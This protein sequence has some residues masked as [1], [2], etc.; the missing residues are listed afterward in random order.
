MGAVFEVVFPVFALIA[1]GYALGKSPL[2]AG[3]AG[4]QALTS[5]VFYAAIPALLFRLFGRG[6]PEGGIEWSIVLG[7]FAA[8]LLHFG[9]TMGVSRFVFRNP[10][11]ELG[12]AGMTASF[13]NTVLMGIPLIYTAFGDDGMLPLLMIVTFHP[14]IL[15]PLA[16]IITE[17]MRGD[18]SQRRSPVLILFNSVKSLAVHP[19]ILGM[20]AGLVFGMTGWT[21]PVVL[22]RLVDML[23]SAATPAALC[24]LGAS[25]TRFSIAGDIK[26]S[27]T[28]VALKLAGLPFL[29]WVFTAHVFDND[30]LWV[31]VATINAAMPCGVNAFLLA[32]YYGTYTQRSASA[33]LIGTGFSVVTVSALF[34][35]MGT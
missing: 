9:L 6:L 35:L 28:L 16:T 30:P 25:L 8:T 10:S 27:L 13:S 7:Y 12:L 2:L 3:E 15:I 1:I 33:I 19:V 22:D 21:L 18:A 32:R 11:V 29:V 23:S 5:F 24:A 31:T 26:E 20:L 4:I 17:S 34:A 14:M